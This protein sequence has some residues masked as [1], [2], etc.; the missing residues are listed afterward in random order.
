MSTTALH[1]GPLAA[2][3]PPPARVVPP[4]QRPAGL[5]PSLPESAATTPARVG[6]PSSTASAADGPILLYDGEC[7]LCDASLRWLLDRDTR[8]A[9]RYATLQGAVGRRLLAEHGL[10]VDLSGAVFIEAGRGATRKS[11]AILRAMAHLP[12]LWRFAAVAEVFP[13]VLR[14]T[15]YDFIAANRYRWFGK[16]DLCRRPSPA[17]RARF[18]G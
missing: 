16:V 7:G 8:G 11:T 3:E 9:I 10:A 13:R 2:V 15:V 1:P 18:L 14:D 6:P 5:A 12:G 17:L 4:P